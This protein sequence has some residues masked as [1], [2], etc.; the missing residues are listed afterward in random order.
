MGRF[1]GK[2]PWNNETEHGYSRTDQ[3]YTADAQTLKSHWETEGYD[4]NTDPGDTSENAECCGP[5]GCRKQFSRI[6]IIQYALD[7]R[8]QCVD[9]EQQ[10]NNEI[11]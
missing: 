1:R 3:E 10:T 8:A 5:N 6:N 11:C 9:R 4:K 2:K 7:A